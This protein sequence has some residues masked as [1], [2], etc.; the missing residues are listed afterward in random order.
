MVGERERLFTPLF[1]ILGH[2]RMLWVWLWQ[3]PGAPVLS[4]VG[5]KYGKILRC[6][7]EGLWAEGS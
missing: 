3:A 1:L 6:A 4:R 2:G 7:T 5:F